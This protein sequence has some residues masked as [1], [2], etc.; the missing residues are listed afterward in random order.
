MVRKQSLQE[1]DMGPGLKVLFAH[2][3]IP[4]S[5]SMFQPP[6][7]RRLFLSKDMSV[8]VL[9]TS[10]RPYINTLNLLKYFFFQKTISFLLK[11]RQQGRHSLKIEQGVGDWP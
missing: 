7:N 9:S 6:A 5:L 2:C 3:T 10:L 8:L 1:A 11:L 4:G